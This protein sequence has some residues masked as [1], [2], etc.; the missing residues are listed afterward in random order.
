MN[1]RLIASAAALFTLVLPS[2]ALAAGDGGHAPEAPP[3]LQLIATIINFCLFIGILVYF[4]RKP[5]REFF[6]NRRDDVVANIEESKRLRE[7]AEA[8]LREYTERVDAFDAERQKMLDE[9]RAIGE[10]EREKIV[11]DATVQAARIRSDAEARAGHE[12]RQARGGVHGDIVERAVELATNEITSRLN[13][14]VHS[15]L[16]D[17]GIA[18]LS[19]AG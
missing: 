19:D 7:E 3:T 1:R 4:G 14:A 10:A 18:S 5:V 13:P 15:Q 16:I 8:K 17:R 11:A 12:A 6:L 2:L 9:Y